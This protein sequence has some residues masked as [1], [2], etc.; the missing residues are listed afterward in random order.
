M[1]DKKDILEILG[2]ISVAYPNFKMAQS[3]DVSTADAY[4]AFLGDI[5]ADVL[6]LAVLK[7][8]SESG[9]AFAPSVGEIRGAVGEIQRKAQ[10]IPSTLDAWDEVCRAE[11]PYP[12]N[13]VMWRGGVQIEPPVH[14]WSH[15]FVEKIAR[16][17]G[18]PDF[19]KFE[20]EGVD[21]AHF[22]KQYESA[23]QNNISEIMELPQVTR[24]IES[25]GEIKKLADGMA[26]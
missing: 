15:P 7:C 12:K 26:K 21:R 23:S 10:G 17:F 1:A 11:K 16:Q 5:P 8:C 25:G 9:R 19:P 4:M 24:Y 6:K 2:L 20:N 22:F 18:W 13:Y 3:G 14:N